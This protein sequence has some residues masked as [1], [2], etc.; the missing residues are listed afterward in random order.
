MK[1]PTRR[2]MLEL[3][4]AVAALPITDARAGAGRSCEHAA[5]LP[6]LL[7]EARQDLGR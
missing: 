7:V 4:A 2:E 1:N 5:I 6:G 3:A